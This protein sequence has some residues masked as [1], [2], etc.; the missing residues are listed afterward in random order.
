MIGFPWAW[1]ARARERAVDCEVQREG[2]KRY[3]RRNRVQGAHTRHI[4]IMTRY[5]LQYDYDYSIVPHASSL[6]FLTSAAG[7]GRPGCRWDTT[8]YTPR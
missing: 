6:V 5:L 8:A 4:T 7:K 2:V 1:G 3:V